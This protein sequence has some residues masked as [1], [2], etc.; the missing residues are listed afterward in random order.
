MLTQYQMR[1]VKHLLKMTHLTVFFC[2]HPPYNVSDVIK[3]AKHL[4]FGLIEGHELI[5]I[6]P[7]SLIRD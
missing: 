7:H 6:D 4:F 3:E 2:S 5:S 1:A